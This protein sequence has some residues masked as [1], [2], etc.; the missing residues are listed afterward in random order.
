[1]SVLFVSEE[2]YLPARRDYSKQSLKKVINVLLVT[3]RRQFPKEIL[4]DSMPPSLSPFA[5]MEIP[6]SRCLTKS[7]QTYI[8]PRGL[9][10]GTQFKSPKDHPGTQYKYLYLI[11][12]R[13]QFFSS[14]GT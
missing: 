13:T 3:I 11:G 4:P 9:T 14:Y 7:L 6:D 2:K 10:A 12:I 8:I 5:L 1:M